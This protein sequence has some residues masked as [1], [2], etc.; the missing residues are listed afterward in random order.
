MYLQLHI[1][2]NY[3]PQTLKN[4]MKNDFVTIKIVGMYEK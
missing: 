1:I 4:V 2:I 3:K